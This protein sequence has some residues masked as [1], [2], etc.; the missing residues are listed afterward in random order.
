MRRALHLAERNKILEKEMR[1]I[2]QI[3][4]EV[5]SE[6]N[7]KVRHNTEKVQRY[8]SFWLLFKI[9]DKNVFVLLTIT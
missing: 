7:S 5:E 2:D 1:E 4:L 9:N 3:A 6:C 8:E